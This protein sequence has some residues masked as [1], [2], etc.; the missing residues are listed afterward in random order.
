MGKKL[1]EPH[2]TNHDTVQVIVARL[3]RHAREN[4]L[5]QK[6]TTVQGISIVSS[7]LVA[8]SFDTVPQG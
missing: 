3:Q 7:A 6:G 2:L 1:A 4:Y 8:A 5:S